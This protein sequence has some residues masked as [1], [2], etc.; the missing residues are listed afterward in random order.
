MSWLRFTIS[1]AAASSYERNW[2]ELTIDAF[3]VES[4][5]S[6]VDFITPG[7]MGLP[8][9]GCLG[10][11]LWENVNDRTD[12]LAGLLSVASIRGRGL[13]LDIVD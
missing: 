5:R 3:D 2:L 1:S 10:I 7:F 6:G 4:P 8:S 13:P 12:T 11:R 9:F